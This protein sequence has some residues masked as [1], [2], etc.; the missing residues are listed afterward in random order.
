M[1]SW[2]SYLVIHSSGLIFAL[3]SPGVFLDFWF[4]GFQLLLEFLFG[5]FDKKGIMFHA[6][7]L[8][9]KGKNW[10]KKSISIYRNLNY[11]EKFQCMEQIYLYG[12][13]ENKCR[14]QS[15]QYGIQEFHLENWS[16]SKIFFSDIWRYL[17]EGKFLLR[18]IFRENQN[19]D[20]KFHFMKFATLLVTFK[21]GPKFWVLILVLICF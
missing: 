2:I 19:F 18:V 20:L 21:I 5:Y 4:K 8:F 9:L 6:W 1:K 13:G 3:R 10:L 12:P 16:A 15:S 14:F 17:Q 11:F 7:I